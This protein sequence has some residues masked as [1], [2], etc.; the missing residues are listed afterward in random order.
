MRHG[1]HSFC[2]PCF[3]CPMKALQILSGLLVLAFFG[4]FVVSSPKPTPPHDPTIKTIL[5]SVLP[6]GTSIEILYDFKVSQHTI[7]ISNNSIDT[8]YNL[9]K[10]LGDE[11]FQGFDE[12]HIAWATDEFLGIREGCG[13]PCYFEIVIPISTN[14][15]PSTYFFPYTN[16]DKGVLLSKNLIAYNGENSSENGGFPIIHLKNLKTN[17]IDSL[18]IDSTWK[19]RGFMNC[20]VDTIYATNEHF[21]I[22]QK[23]KSGRLI[24]KKEKKT[25]LQ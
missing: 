23:D 19:I 7:N 22:G 13:S 14:A 17:K 10:T 20:F 5:D 16:W 3:F 8:S 18:V 2:L 4:A 9:C 12:K 11:C 24:A 15:P 6:N 25:N 21:M 1:R